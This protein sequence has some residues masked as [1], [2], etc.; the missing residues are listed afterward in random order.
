MV[1]SEAEFRT[2][3]VMGEKDRHT[4]YAPHGVQNKLSE[5][6]MRVNVQSQS[7]NERKGTHCGSCQ[8]LL[9]CDI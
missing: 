2:R 4:P 9:N 3:P 6:D 7:I 1:V 5:S 8:A